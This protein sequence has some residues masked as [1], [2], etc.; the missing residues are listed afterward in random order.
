MA[1]P[2]S[3]IIGTGATALS[4]VPSIIEAGAGFRKS[5]K[6]R[7]AELERRAAM[8]AL[9][10]TPAQEEVYRTSL[11]SPAQ[12]LARQQMVEQRALTA[13]TGGGAGQDFQAMLN[14]QEAE[15]RRL[16]EAQAKISQADMELQLQQEAEMRKLASA[17]DEAR[18]KRTAAIIGGIADVGAQAF[19]AGLELRRFKELT[20][21]IPAGRG[22][23]A[24]ESSYEDDFLGD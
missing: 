23:G 5:D 21:A 9:G 2:K 3:A 7:L 24:V 18:A 15:Q 4:T 6:E 12:A 13:T 20:G 11:L 8:G 22:K 1:I 17:Q 10:F 16:A 19:G 14:A